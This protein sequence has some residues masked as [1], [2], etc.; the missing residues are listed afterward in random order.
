MATGLILHRAHHVAGLSS[1]AETD[2]LKCLMMRR[3]IR[4]FWSYFS[5]DRLVTSS[6]G[7]NCTIHWQRVRTEFYI[8]L[9]QGNATV[10]DIAHDSFCRL[11]HLWDSCMDQVYVSHFI[12]E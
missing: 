9:V 10:D 11:W 4:S 1:T 2:E 8:S 5:V 7:M 3:K 6:L 12:V